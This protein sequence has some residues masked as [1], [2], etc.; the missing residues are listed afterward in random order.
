LGIGNKEADKK[1][2]L[3]GFV[4]CAL[5]PLGFGWVGAAPVGG[6]LASG[7]GAGEGGVRLLGWCFDEAVFYRV[8]WM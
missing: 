6:V 3:R 4:Q 5:A 1:S 7:N 2:V 8:E